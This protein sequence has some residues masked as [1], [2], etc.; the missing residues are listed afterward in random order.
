MA[1]KILVVATVDAPEAALR[2]RLGERAGEDAEIVVV[3]PSADV[4]LLQWLATE[5]D[6]ARERAVERAERTAAAVGGAV[7]DAGAGDTDPV[8]AIEDALRRFPADEIVVVTRPDEEAAWLE[9]G[10]G[11]LAKERFGVPVT[12][13]VAED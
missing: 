4:S 11:E 12:H 5:E 13:L 3:A 8:Q 9:R 2:S 1:R 7:V 6:G 10:S